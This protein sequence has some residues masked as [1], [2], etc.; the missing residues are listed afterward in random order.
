MILLIQY[1]ILG[2]VQGFTEFLPVS[3]SAHLVFLQAIFKIEEN[4][5]LVSVSLHAGTLLA[6]V[7]FFK[8]DTIGLLRDSLKLLKAGKKKEVGPRI[9]YYI[10][11]VTLI[12]GV[13]GLGG[14]NFFEDLF[15]QPRRAAVMLLVTALVLF[16]TK[17][18]MKGKRKLSEL[19]VHDA[20]IMGLV[21]GISIIPG[22]SRSGITIASLLWRG[23]DRET[24]FKFS[25]LAS[26]PAVLGA[27]ILEV[28]K[29]TSLSWGQAGY[30]L[31]GLII[32]FVSGLIALAVLQKI[33]QRAKFSLFGYYCLTIAL[34]GWLYFT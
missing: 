32:A 25:F 22:I 21:Q 31:V 28:H 17:K 33:I 12:T 13:I 2:I 1:I 15:S 20:W 8:R 29:L 27:L 30:L 16:S 9:V 11:I 18:F 5:V 7:L 26:I 24:A 19:N 3:S 4:H 10:L 23:V 14:G 6:L 34:L